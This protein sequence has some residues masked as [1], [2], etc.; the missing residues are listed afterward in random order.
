MAAARTRRRGTA[1]PAARHITSRAAS[2]LV[3]VAVT[4]LTHATPEAA[5]AQANQVGLGAYGEPLRFEAPPGAALEVAG[6]GRYSETMEVRAARDGRLVAINDV[7]MRTYLEGL[8]EM[9]TSW[10]M[11]ALKAQAVA[12]RTYAWYSILLG[13]FRAQGYD[14]CA[15]VACQVFRGREPGES[16]GGERWVQAVASTEGEVLVDGSAPILA[17]YFSSSGGHTRD[18]EEVFPG[19]GPRPYL[20]GVPDPEDAVSPLHLWQVRFTRVEFD[21]IL[22]R[23]QSLSRAVPIL[24]VAFVAAAGGEPDRVAV[25][26]VGGTSVEVTASEFR[27]FVSDMAPRLFPDR[28]PSSRA[29]GRRLPETLPSSRLAFTITPDE[30]VVDGRGFGHGVGM[31]QY[32][33]KGKAEAGMK[34]DDILAAYYGGLRPTR[35]EDLPSRVRVG[36]DT[37]GRAFRLRADGATRVLAG[38][39]V[40]TDRA[41]GTWRV[42]RR[43]DRAMDL[44]AP[45]GY[46]A[47]LVAS[48]TQA[49]DPTPREVEVVTVDTVVNKAAELFLVVTDE[50]GDEVTKR[51]IGVVEPGRRAVPFDL[52]SADGTPLRPGRYGVEL[53]AIDES[54]AQAG[55]PTRL[56]VMPLTISSARPSSLL[57][58]VATAGGQGFRLVLAI[59][60]GALAGLAI[61]RLAGADT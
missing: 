52:D 55:A 21:A 3:I 58:P 46:G 59:A 15:G 9:P 49:R 41:L 27:R 25:T 4:L 24:N 61:G 44:E 19:E 48:P 57:E 40:I 2:A 53:R 5:V 29:D 11:E 56:E 22:S 12:A 30:V 35:A 10:P 16:P 17:R 37:S 39:Q 51:R 31:S 20:Q 26:G 54:G 50:S 32:G 13:T 36:V 14:L 23:G 45:S 6:V 1:Q 8:A 47:P 18:N 28:F 38:G 33:A 42:S 60:V 7:S 34:Y 43:P